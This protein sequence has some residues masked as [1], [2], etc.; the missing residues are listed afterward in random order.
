MP[1]GK[2]IALSEIYFSLF[3][4]TKFFEFSFNPLRKIKQPPGH[5]DRVC[6]I[7]DMI[8]LYTTYYLVKLC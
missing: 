5:L 2:T 4:S 7:F 1:G 3:F 6:K 8:F